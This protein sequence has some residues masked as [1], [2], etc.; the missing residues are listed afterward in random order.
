MSVIWVRGRDWLRD[1][2]QDFVVYSCR[3]V[4]S[5]MYLPCEAI[6]YTG[7]KLFTDCPYAEEN[8]GLVNVVKLFEHFGEALPQLI[9][10]CVYIHNNGGP[11]THPINTT[12]AVFSAGSLAI[13]IFTSIK[14]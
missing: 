7:K 9:L 4:L 8:V 2:C 10:S 12:S 11:L 13:G 5:L 14:V 1:W 6:R 3:G